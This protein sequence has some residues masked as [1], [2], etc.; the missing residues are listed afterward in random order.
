[1][2]TKIELTEKN[3][4]ES[5]KKFNNEIT[6]TKITHLPGNWDFRTEENKMT[7]LENNLPIA[8]TMFYIN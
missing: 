6:D 1:M 4:M 7:W 3:V 2:K 5:I 8:F